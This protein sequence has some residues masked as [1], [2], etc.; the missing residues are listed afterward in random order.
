MTNETASQ[1][2]QFTNTALPDV[3]ELRKVS[4]SYDGGKTWVIQDLDLLIEDIPAQGQF[5]VILGKSGCGKS[6]L[7][8]YIAGLQ[9]PTAG[10]VLIDGK[11]RTEET[12]ISMVFQQYSSF[13]WMSVLENVMLPLRLKGVARKEAEEQALKMIETVGLSGHEK[14]FAKY[15]L[16]S[17]GQLQR[18]AIARSLISNPHIILM[19]EPFGAL[20]THTRSQMQQLLLEIWVKLESTIIFVTHDIQEAV[21]LGD[22]IYIMSLNPGRIV[23]HYHVGLPLQ[24]D[25]NTKKEPEFI[26]LVSEIDEAI[27]SF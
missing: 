3:I 25:R 6:T 26:R 21:L 23:K 2:I 16:L 13:P 4:Q 18:V 11:P 9:K 5:V 7:L 20:D 14:K 17:G 22:D 27:M 19:D 10:E 8:R 12:V 1:V 24:R 15:P